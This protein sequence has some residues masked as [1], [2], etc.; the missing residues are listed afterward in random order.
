MPQREQSERKSYPMILRLLGSMTLKGGVV[1]RS[2]KLGDLALSHTKQ[3][4]QSTPLSD[5]AR[6]CPRPSSSR[7]RCKCVSALTLGERTEP[8]AWGP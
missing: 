6:I 2:R 8:S 5:T 1:P 4:S 3:L 7:V